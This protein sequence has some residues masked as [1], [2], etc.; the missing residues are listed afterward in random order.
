MLRI[1]S[2]LVALDQPKLTKD[3]LR[4]LIDDPLKQHVFDGYDPA[5]VLYV[6]ERGREV[7]RGLTALRTYMEAHPTNKVFLGGNP[8]LFDLALEGGGA[9]GFAHMGT[10]HAM[11]LRGIWFDRVSGTSAGSIAAALVAGG[12]QVD[13]NYKTVVDT[14]IRGRLTPSRDNSLNQVMFDDQFLEFTDFEQEIEDVRRLIKRENSVTSRFIRDNIRAAFEK[15]LSMNAIKDGIRLTERQVRSAYFNIE[16]AIIGAVMNFK[17]LGIIKIGDFGI[18]GT[19]INVRTAVNG[20]QALS[21]FIAAPLR[22]AIEELVDTLLRGV[23]PI[24]DAFEIAVRNVTEG[25]VDKVADSLVEGLVFERGRLNHSAYGLYR[26]IEFGGFWEGNFV[27]DWLEEHLQQHNT[28]SGELLDGR[29]G[30]PLKDSSGR[31]ARAIVFKDLKIDLCVVAADM[32]PI[33]PDKPRTPAPVF[34]SKRTTPDY[35]VA[36]AVRRSISLPF[37]FIPRRIADGYGNNP[38]NVNRQLVPGRLVGGKRTL[39]PLPAGGRILPSVA[40]DNQ[41]HHGHLMFDG[42]LFF[43]LP[44]AVFRDPTDFVFDKKQDS[45]PLVISNINANEV[46]STCPDD[47][48]LNEYPEPVASL[49]KTLEELVPQAGPPAYLGLIKAAR[50]FEFTMSYM[51]TE[52]QETELNSLMRL[53]PNSLFVDMPLRDPGATAGSAQEYASEGR[54]DSGNFAMSKTTKKWM[55]KNGF[56]GAKAALKEFEADV[57][58]LRDKLQLPDDLDPYNHLLKLENIRLRNGGAVET[59]RLAKLGDKCYLGSDIKVSNRSSLKLGGQLRVGYSPLGDHWIKIANNDANR[60]DTGDDFLSFE[61]NI[62][63]RVLLA[64]DVVP[65]FATAANGW[66][67]SKLNLD[68]IVPGAV[69]VLMP[70]GVPTAFPTTSL[71]IFSK[72]FEKG[73]VRIPG[74]RNRTII[75]NKFAYLILVRPV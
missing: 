9:F 5:Q 21:D 16:A 39:F 50:A 73:R 67:T 15:H 34:F 1:N 30:R 71:E 36:E 69:P 72:L 19:Q 28:G 61:I 49:K 65:T 70:P 35:P 60:G 43:N 18:P 22:N 11:A 55:V 56:D 45:K 48:P 57:P 25:I 75:N 26:L 63:S 29:N 12:Y 59:A 68:I 74:P 52:H 32:G 33:D 14:D 3:V 31:P 27:R 44:I 41:R 8:K 23:G 13:L 17:V 64:L 47:V 7:A 24:Y 4:I 53:V 62:R 10:L 58:A 37:V 6:D 54:I 20:S 38:P 2:T 42:G 46:A 51:L 40:Y 66:E